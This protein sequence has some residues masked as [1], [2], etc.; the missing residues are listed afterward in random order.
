MVSAPRN[1][2]RS[3]N[4]SPP[5]R[6]TQM[7]RDG[8][9][10]PARRV[11]G[12][13]VSS[14]L[15]TRRS[16]SRSVAEF[17]SR[18]RPSNRPE[19]GG[20]ARPT[21]ED[22]EVHQPVEYNSPALSGRGGRKRPSSLSRHGPDT[23]P[24]SLWNMPV[25][26]PRR[27]RSVGAKERTPPV[28][29]SSFHTNRD[30]NSIQ[31]CLHQH[32]RRVH[33]DDKLNR[34]AVYRLY[35]SPPTVTSRPLQQ[36]NHHHY[37]PLPHSTVPIPAPSPPISHDV[38]VTNCALR[39]QRRR[40]LISSGDFLGV[41]GVNPYTGEPDVVTPP[42]GSDDAIVTT[43]S[44]SSALIPP[45]PPPPTTTPTTTCSGG[46]SSSSWPAAVAHVHVHH[47][48]GRR[49]RRCGPG[50][51]GGGEDDEEAGARRRL[52]REEERLQRAEQR[53]EAL[54]EALAQS[55]VRWRQE[56]G[57]WRSSVAEPKLS[58]IL[59]SPP[60]SRKSAASA[61]QSASVRSAGG[62]DV[63]VVPPMTTREGSFLGT[64]AAAVAG[65][66]SRRRRRLNGEDVGTTES[67]G[68]ALETVLVQQ[69]QQ[70]Q[71]GE[72]ILRP[73][74]EK[75]RGLAGGACPLREV[76][77]Q[78]CLSPLDV[79]QERSAQQTGG[80]YLERQQE[81]ELRSF[82]Y[83][84]RDFRRLLR[85]NTTQQV[86]G[87]QWIREL[88]DL[89]WTEPRD[90]SQLHKSDGLSR[91][92]DFAAKVRPREIFHRSG[93]VLQS[94][95]TR[96]TTTTGFVHSQPRHRIAAHPCDAML[97][98]WYEAPPNLRASVLKAHSRSTSP[99]FSTTTF[100]N[101]S[102]TR[103]A[104]PASTQLSAW[105]SPD[106]SDPPMTEAMPGKGRRDPALGSRSL[107]LPLVPE[108]DSDTTLSSTDR[109]MTALAQEN[110]DAVSAH[111]PATGDKEWHPRRRDRGMRKTM[112]NTPPAPGRFHLND[113]ADTGKSSRT[114]TRMSTY[115]STRRPTQSWQNEGEAFAR[116]AAR[117]AFAHHEETT[118][119]MRTPISAPVTSPRRRQGKAAEAMV[120]SADDLGKAAK[121]NEMRPGKGEESQERTKNVEGR[122]EEKS[123]MSTP[124]VRCWGRD[125]MMMLAKVVS[126]YWQVVNPVFDGDSELRKRLDESRATRGDVV[127]CVLAVVF[128][129]L[130]LSAGVWSVRGIVWAGR[131]LGKLGEALGVVVGLCG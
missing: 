120:E 36:S 45:P 78:F 38:A 17:F 89:G 16:L 39:R 81:L 77:V 105:R 103:L 3:S 83:V 14:E 79:C 92:S 119:T 27:A 43:T 24:S 113:E 107:L 99:P 75:T 54:R 55:G 49:H 90:E 116:G 66:S 23:I 104:S 60:G 88:H 25:T 108:P 118:M 126:A 4:P 9:D 93:W 69:Q 42:T 121:T 100:K 131:L 11:K 44:S 112:R 34:D 72:A 57:G 56:E 64:P 101:N 12:M 52:R 19:R 47:A 73:V 37:A 59:Q 21:T 15:V 129:F 98:R 53:K 32:P 128:L 31:G 123:N 1:V 68:M 127:V 7:S 62:G 6:R 26:P 106:K 125:G 10:T 85:H 86:P 91:R 111:Q 82:V 80:I 102:S 46:G 122:T 97:G 87:G 115:H 5:S 51:Y 22:S 110:Q 30:G 109:E 50:Y 117:T 74:S 94:V 124:E 29:Q 2:G 63:G 40:T 70:Q 13:T 71:H 33:N 95:C 61:S 130:V 48:G 20:T 28:A 96:T 58:P 8:K 35:H 65:V 41:T 84:P 76:M 114:Y 18:L 67:I